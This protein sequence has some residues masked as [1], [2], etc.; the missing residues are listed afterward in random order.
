MLTGEMRPLIPDLFENDLTMKWSVEPQTTVTTRTFLETTGTTFPRLS[1][2]QEV[3]K[4]T[5]FLFPNGKLQMKRA[6]SKAV[7][8]CHPTKRSAISL[9]KLRR[10]KL[11]PRDRQ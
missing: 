5:K 10:H 9:C 2:M 8:I 3:F 11:L 1:E 4:A 6:A 7:S